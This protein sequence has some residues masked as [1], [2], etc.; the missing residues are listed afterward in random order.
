MQSS[1]SHSSEVIIFN[2]LDH[3][4]NSKVMF[5]TTDYETHK[6]QLTCWEVLKRIITIIHI[7]QMY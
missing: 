5:Q 3:G 7:L 2:A 4:I 6:S 1:R